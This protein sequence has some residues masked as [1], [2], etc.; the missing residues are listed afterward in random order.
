MMIDNA[1]ANAG[2]FC[3]AQRC[4]SKKT[5]VVVYN[6]ITAGFEN[7]NQFSLVSHKIEMEWHVENFAT[8]IFKFVGKRPNGF[9]VITADVEGKV[10]PGSTLQKRPEPGG[11][12]AGLK[13]AKNVQS[14][15]WGS[16]TAFVHTTIISRI[17]LAFA[18]NVLHKIN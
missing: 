12:S 7:F 10:L 11:D 13:L 15:D 6:S 1:H 9:S 18:L 5:A 8:K 2:P 16:L 14:L 17:R 4:S 3:S